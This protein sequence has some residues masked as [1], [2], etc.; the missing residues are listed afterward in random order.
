MTTPNISI[1]KHIRH[2]PA[3]PIEPTSTLVLMSH[4]SHFVDIRIITSPNDSLPN[5]DES[6]LS[7]LDWAFAGISTSS[8]PS[9]PGGPYHS[10][11]SHWIDSKTSNP[12]KDEGMMYVQ[13]GGDVLECGE[14]INKTT[15]E[16]DK[17]EELWGDVPVQRVRK[18]IED[19]EGHV[20][21]VAEAE[22]AERSIRG[23]IVRVG[24]WC[25][26]ILKVG[27][28]IMVE[29]WHW[30]GGGGWESIARLGRGKL[31]QC[32]LMFEE[33]VIGEGKRYEYE[34]LEWEIVELY[35][36]K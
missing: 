9:E 13:P 1:R 36:W 10:A 18:R 23:M 24:D 7:S 25:Q 26:G 16:V 30:T 5:S 32:A 22:D 11:W 3:D 27:E 21:I 17:Y 31:L 33:G 29:R 6:P 35:H 12:E 8:T 28:E 34:G 15:G 4:S 19:G 2:P 20:S 14:N